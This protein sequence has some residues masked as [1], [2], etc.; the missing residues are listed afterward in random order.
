M[1]PLV[2]FLLGLGA[3]VGDMAESFIKRRMGFDRGA[4]LFLMDQ[5][6]YIFGAFFFAWTVV[7]LQSIGLGHL[8][9]TCALTVPIH[10]IASVVAWKLKLKKNPW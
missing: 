5:L 3:L 4:H 1:T 8:I 6:D 10:Y 7:P 9:L 2:G